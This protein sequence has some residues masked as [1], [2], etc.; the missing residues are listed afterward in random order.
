MN[1][2]YLAGFFD[3]EGCISI[4][5]RYGS[6]GWKTR[7]TISQSD[8]KLI[9]LQKEVGIGHIHRVRPSTRFKSRQGYQWNINRAAHVELFLTNVLPYLRFKRRQAKWAILLCDRSL[10]LEEQKYIALQIKKAKR[11]L[12]RQD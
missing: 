4:H 10:S 9:V 8:K 2:A 6:D 3:G 12:A 11:A 7:L 1:W 5:S